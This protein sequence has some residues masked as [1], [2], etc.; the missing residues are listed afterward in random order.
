MQQIHMQFQIPAW[1]PAWGAASA[2]KGQERRKAMADILA[3]TQQE[4]SS[5]VD[6]LGITHRSAV[7]YAS[8]WEGHSVSESGPIPTDAHLVPSGTTVVMAKPPDFQ[9]LDDDHEI[10]GLSGH[11]YAMYAK[12]QDAIFTA[13]P[14][15]GD[16]IKPVRVRTKDEEEMWR[17]QF[18]EWTL[19]KNAFNPDIAAAQ[20]TNVRK[21]AELSAPPLNKPQDPARTSEN[22]RA[23]LSDSS[24]TGR[25]PR[26]WKEKIGPDTY[27]PASMN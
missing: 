13:K 9:A 15:D 20:R 4:M 5:T 6:L 26:R 24:I 16:P 18:M 3:K 11:P 7:P 22:V 25:A 19:Q 12:P 27:F 23:A 1:G 14:L 8:T 21:A 2:L 10:L 17:A